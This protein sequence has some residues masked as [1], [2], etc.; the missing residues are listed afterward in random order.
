MLKA[1]RLKTAL[2]K[3]KLI[4]VHGPWSRAVEFRH[5]YVPTPDPLWGGASRY[6]CTH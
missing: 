6:R 1:Q 4:A 2:A 5:L 3:A